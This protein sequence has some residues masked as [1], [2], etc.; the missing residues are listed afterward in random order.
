MSA[1]GAHYY[2]SIMSC[3]EDVYSR[4]PIFL[5]KSKEYKVPD[6]VWTGNFY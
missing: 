3:L 2:A 6:R 1:L 4:S 5:M